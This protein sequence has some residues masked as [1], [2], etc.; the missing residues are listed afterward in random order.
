[1]ARVLWQVVYFP[2][3]VIWLTLCAVQVVCMWPVRGLDWML[4]QLAPGILLVAWRADGGE[5]N[6]PD[7]D[8]V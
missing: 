1:M 7:D 5:G 4:G 6:P 2:M 3:A 8:D